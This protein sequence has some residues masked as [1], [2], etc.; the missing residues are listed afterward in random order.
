MNFSHLS[1]AEIVLEA[2]NGKVLGESLPHYAYRVRADGVSFPECKH[3]L[4]GN[5]PVCEIE[6]RS[7]PLLLINIEPC[8]SPARGR[9]LLRCGIPMLP[10]TTRPDLREMITAAYN[11]K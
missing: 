2:L 8:Y 5:N 4:D 1:D 6:N 7:C 3:K 11:R 10:E 9:K